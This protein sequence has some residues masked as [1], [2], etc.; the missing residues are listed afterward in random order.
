MSK[1]FKG[2]AMTQTAN[3]RPEFYLDVNDVMQ[4]LN[5]T[6]R[7]LRHWEEKGLLTPE[8]GRNRYTPKDVKQLRLIKRL[9]VEEGFP[10]EV[11][12]RMFERRLWD[13]EFDE[14]VFDR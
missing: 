9:V 4:E 12:R 7:Q 2:T 11:V 5:V 6:R 10:V 3:K 14:S 13:D 8:I 1:H